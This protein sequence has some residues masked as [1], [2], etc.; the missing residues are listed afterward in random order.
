MDGV[1]TWHLVPNDEFDFVSLL[2]DALG[3]LV[4]AGSLCVVLELLK[5]ALKLI[6]ADVDVGALFVV[7]GLDERDGLVVSAEVAGLVCSLVS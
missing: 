4:G 5:L 3:F 6:D 7:H 2:K 1:E